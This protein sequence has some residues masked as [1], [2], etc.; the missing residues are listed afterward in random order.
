MDWFKGLCCNDRG[1]ILRSTSAPARTSNEKSDGPSNKAADHKGRNVSVLSSTRLTAAQ[2]KQRTEESKNVEGMA[3]GGISMQYCYVSQRGFYPDEPSKENQDSF[4][5]IPSYQVRWIG[6]SLAAH[7]VSLLISPPHCRSSRTAKSPS[8]ESSTG[9][10]RCARP[11]PPTRPHHRHRHHHP[12]VNLSPP[13]ATFP[14]FPLCTTRP[15]TRVRGS[16][17]TSCRRTCLRSC[18]RRGGPT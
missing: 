1:A 4:C 12:R 13:F 15:G 5:M 7:P 9:T 6:A 16:S 8:S 14:S 18:R 11:R 10:G 2:V 17:A 3:I